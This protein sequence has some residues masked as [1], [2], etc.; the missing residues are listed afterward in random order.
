VQE[1][2][3]GW[4]G[5][6]DAG[7]ASAGGYIKIRGVAGASRDTALGGSHIGRGFCSSVRR[8]SICL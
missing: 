8:G 2:C 6:F 5:V 4:D 1:G 7:N 3:V